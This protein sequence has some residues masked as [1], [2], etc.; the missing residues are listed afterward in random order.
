MCISFRPKAANTL[1]S[2]EEVLLLP[3]DS[4]SPGSIKKCPCLDTLHHSMEKEFSEMCSQGSVGRV[5][6]LL[7]AIPVVSSLIW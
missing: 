2:H 7:T 3:L 5:L 4:E 1:Q 6:G